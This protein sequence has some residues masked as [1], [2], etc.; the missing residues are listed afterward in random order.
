MINHSASHVLAADFDYIRGIVERNYVGQGVLCDELRRLLSSRLGRPSVTLTD[1][2]TAAL[3]L[4]LV[5]L[6]AKGPG[7]RHV[8]VGAYVC[9]EVISAVMRAGLEPV[10]ID[11]RPD[12]LNVDMAAMAARVDARTLAAVCTG[13]GGAPDDIGAAADWNVAVI[14]DCAQA[15]GS[16]VAGREVGSLGTCTILSFGPTKMLSAG[17][18]GAF[19]G[20]EDLGRDVASLA[21][22][23]LPAEEYRRSGFRP[24]FGQHM[25]DLTAG[26]AAA[27]MRRLDAIVA[28]RRQIAEAYDRALKGNADTSLV[29]EADLV[30]SNRFRY[31]F[32]SESADAWV[33]HL[34]M[35]DIDARRSIAHVI[36]EYLGDSS[37][38]P[39]LLRLARRVVSVPIYPAMTV[40]QVDFVA[41]ALA[42]GPIRV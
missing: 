29:P 25:G 20:A 31:Y 17:A 7:K 5:A 34:R 22:G 10:L 18:G 19:L 30:Q 9:P 1:S 21:L 8:L 3:H 28:R 15:I 12:S 42:L 41:A 36:P 16:C 24:S 14:S 38:Y 35:R 40:A 32:F 37:A 26:L 6:A 11:C 27:Q 13:I 23:E 2:G 39:N 4:C 33:A